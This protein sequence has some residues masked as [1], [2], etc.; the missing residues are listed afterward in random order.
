MAQNFESTEI[1][2]NDKLMAL[3]SWLIEAIVPLIVLLSESSKNRKFQRFHA[4]NSLLVT[5][6]EVILYVLS[7]CLSF[8]GIGFVCFIVVPLVALGVRIYFGI[9]AYQ[10][11]Y[12]EVPGLTQLA[13]NQKW[14]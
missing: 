14:L 10:G 9:K 8:V 13:K 1:N 12:T 6:V 2:D 3:L 4:I 5:A 11:D 7:T